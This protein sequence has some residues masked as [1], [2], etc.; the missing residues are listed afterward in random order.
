MMYLYELFEGDLY[1]YNVLG[2]RMGDAWSTVAK[3]MDVFP[4]RITNELHPGAPT[5][6]AVYAFLKHLAQSGRTVDELYVGLLKTGLHE[7]AESLR[8]MKE[9]KEASLAVIGE[10]KGASAC[11]RC[12]WTQPSAIVQSRPAMAVPPRSPD[13]CKVDSDLAMNIAPRC[14]QPGPLAGHVS[15]WVPAGGR[16]SHLP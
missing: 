6:D 8:T 5:R 14:G 15:R 11:P 3:N 4:E 9:T 13:V 2:D 7:T 12:S 10:R 16:A 1:L